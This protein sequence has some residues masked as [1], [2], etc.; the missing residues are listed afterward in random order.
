M[1]KI[2]AIV[3]DRN[4]FFHDLVYLSIK[5]I[6]HKVDKIILFTIE[7]NDDLYKKWEKESYIEIRFI[8][9]IDLINKIGYF[10]T[11]IGYNLSNEFNNNDIIFVAG[12]DLIFLNDPF[13]YFINNIG[14]NLFLNTLVKQNSTEVNDVGCFFKNCN[15]SR[16][17]LKNLLLI[18][19]K[20]EIIEY[21]NYFPEAWIESMGSDWFLHQNILTNIYYKNKN[22]KKYFNKWK[23]IYN[24]YFNWYCSG[25]GDIFSEKSFTHNTKKN[26][27][28]HNKIEANN[29]LCAEC[30]L[31]SSPEQ[32]DKI[33]IN[34]N[35][36]NF[37]YH[38][39]CIGNK[40][41]LQLNN[42]ICT[43]CKYSDDNI[44]YT[45]PSPKVLLYINN[46]IKKILD[47]NMYSIQLV[48]RIKYLLNNN[49]F[50]LLKS[51]LIKKEYINYS[52]WKIFINTFNNYRVTC[53]Y[54]NNKIKNNLKI[55][56][57]VILIP[58]RNREKHLSYYLNN[59]VPLI[60]KYLPNTKILIIEQENGKSFN[61]GK[62]LNIGFLEYKYKTKYFI[63]NDVDINPKKFVIQKVF[64]INIEENS[65]LG[66]LTSTCNTLGGLIKML[67]KT[68][69]KINGFPNNIWGWGVED[70]LLQERSN[71][72]EIE[73]KNLYNKPHSGKNQ[74]IDNNLFKIFDHNREKNGYKMRYRKYHHFR[75][76]S[77]KEKKEEINKN[78][79]NTLE[80]KILEINNI[81]ELITI[82][83]VK[84]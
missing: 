65:I 76:L 67:N 62:L 50:N 32:E 30:N 38:N 75:R 55:Y 80:Y 52:N 12:D 17:I 19:D 8:K 58:Y 82:I 18:L 51:L 54:Y 33:L 35:K 20:K 10:C 41:N 79:I 21:K 6:S 66:I 73:K 83:K 26:I 4:E 13:E 71:V 59:T 60:K 3:T 2:L 22:F 48:G 44:F 1:L 72:F 28:E 74:N 37:K 78:G 64:S 63:T 7:Q 27:I 69:H 23:F 49:Y 61:R 14:N 70:K 84:I 53:E 25:Y 29:K 56:D 16:N 68:I 11:E 24:D 5:K 43:Y 81:D 9:Q 47:S 42:W 46:I 45:E 77:I 34:C 39:E 57:N 31:V 15:E 36:C 40:L